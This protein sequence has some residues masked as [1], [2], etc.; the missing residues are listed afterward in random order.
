[1]AY[2]VEPQ[3]FT[4]FKGIREQN[5]I[6]SGGVI[7]AI[8][9]QNVEIIPTEIGESTGIKTMKGNAPLYAVPSGYKVIGIFN[10]NQDG[11]DYL[12]VYAENNA[13]G[14]NQG[15]LYYVDPSTFV[16]TEA[17]TGL[18]V[19]GECNGITMTSSAYDVFVFTNGVEAKTYCFA[20]T[21]KAQTITAT[22]YQ[23]R[24]L[25]WLAMCEWNGFLVVADQ[26]GVHGSHQNDI[27]TWN[28]NPTDV[29]NSW[30]IDFSKKTTAVYSYT[31]GLYIFTGSDVTFLNTTPNDT[32][33]SKMQTVAGIGCFSYSSIVKHDIY[34]FFYDDNQ[35]NVYFIQN[36]DSGQIR[37]AGPVAR[38]IQTHFN[39]VRR[40]KMTSCIYEN[41][42]EVWCIINDEILIYDYVRQ[43]WLKRTEQAI[44]SVCLSGNSVI[45]GGDD[46]KVYAEGYN[47][48]FSGNFYPATYQT[49]YINL[50]T[51]TNLKKQ[52]TP[53]LIVLNDEYVN[54]FWVQLTVNNKPKNPKRIKRGSKSLGIYAADNEPELQVPD[55]RKKFAMVD[56]E[57]GEITTPGAKYGA[58]NIYVKTVVEVSTPQTW[59]TMSIKIYTDRA[60]QGFCIDSMELKNIK[61]KTK[62]KGR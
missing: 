36:I 13:V 49:C 7:S 28:D 39:D 54:D 38:E 9:C 25:Q 12:F 21:P 1:M 26:Y 27:Y 32:T 17:I 20:A 61:M 53:L 52:K 44:N 14:V 19:T 6:S 37:P 11:I 22:D 45:S 10:S 15:I 59:Y 8:E 35:K 60:G 51:N 33:N 5:G 23:G 40:F 62:T 42:N 58:K 24:S 31:G 30:Y 50:G 29:A 56:E 18:T 47:T 48:N 55:A 3:I 41:K 57:T 16:L 2:A 34:L 46:G 4:Q 43:E